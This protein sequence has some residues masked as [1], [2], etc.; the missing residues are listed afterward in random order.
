MSR[1]AARDRRQLTALVGCVLLAACGPDSTSGGG[2]TVTTGTTS[3][4]DVVIGDASGDAT[5]A[6]TDPSDATVTTPSDVA[7]DANSGG[8]TG[9]AKRADNIYVLST[10]N[11]LYRFEPGAK[12]FTKIGPLS[13]NAGDG[14]PNS[15]AIARDGTAWVDYVSVDPFFGDD[16]AG[17]LFEVSTEDASCKPVPSTTLPVNWRRLGMGF[18]AA[19]VDNDGLYV[20]G[21]GDA[22]QG[23]AKVDTSNGQLTPIAPF[24]APFAGLSAELTGTADGRLFGFFVGTPPLAIA[25][26]DPDD[27]SIVSYDTLN[28]PQPIAWAFSLYR[29]AFYLYTATVDGLGFPTTST[30]SRYDYETNTLDTTYIPDVGFTIVGA[31][32]STCATGR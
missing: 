5:S 12:R 7:D 31:G 3:A 24:G 18:V 32:V 16:T 10:D 6:T 1:A 2:A 11:D 4:P 17:A 23:L 21:T 20:T 13:C 9:C 28:L 14:M 30:V 15:M 27:G 22:S 8:L 19:D 26:V 25:E 29:N